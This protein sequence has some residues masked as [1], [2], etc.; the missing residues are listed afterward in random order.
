LVLVF[1]DDLLFASRVEAG[2]GACG[3]RARF[4]TDIG[5]LGEALKAA[6]VLI[7]ANVGS[8]GVDWPGMVALAKERRLPPHAAVVGYG[9]HVDLDLRQRALDAGCDAV[10]A[11]SAVASGMA[12]LLERHAWKPDL[13]ACDQPLPAGV[14]QGVEQ[15]NRREFYAC[16]DSIELVWVDEPGDVRLMYQGILQISVAFYQVQQGNWPGMVKMMARG[17]GKLLPFL[18][19]CQGIDLEGLLVDLEGCEAALG[20][21]G[22]QGMSAFDFH[23]ASIAEP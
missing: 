21:L 19:R 4:V 22:S 11:R 12:S 3:Y 7:L 15:F 13:S 6:P 1:E 18:P 17:K 9:P 10:V 14:L 5:E 20:E 8:Q 16:H 2:L 23:P